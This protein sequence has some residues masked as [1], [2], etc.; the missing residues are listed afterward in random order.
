MTWVATVLSV[1]SAFQFPKACSASSPQ[2]RT[3]PSDLTAQV[4][5][6]PAA[7]EI[8]ELIPDTNTGD[9][10]SVVSAFQFH[11]CCCE[12]S[13][14][15]TTFPVWV[16]AQLWFHP[17]D[18]SCIFDRPDTCI[19]VYLSVVSTLPLPSCCCESSPQHQTSPLVDIPQLWK[20]HA[21]TVCLTSNPRSP[22]PSLSISG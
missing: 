1:V 3:V 18:T 14:R 6:H 16:V 21:A 2:H 9:S 20:Y 4:W 8:T 10:L 22:N 5:P 19:G 11:N 15:H 12:S 7:R 17:A 13:H